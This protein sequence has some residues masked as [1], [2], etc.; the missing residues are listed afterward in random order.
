[1]SIGALLV[2]L[3]FAAELKST[4]GVREIEGRKCEKS[5]AQKLLKSFIIA[6]FDIRPCGCPAEQIFLWLQIPSSPPLYD[7][8]GKQLRNLAE[9]CF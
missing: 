9:N 3:A 2:L 6:C 8:V 4:V 1:M 7:S 5:S